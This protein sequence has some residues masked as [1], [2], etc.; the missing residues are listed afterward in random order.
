MNYKAYFQLIRPKHYL[1][2]VLI[3][4]PLVFGGH[5]FDSDYLLKSA[6][7]F[8]TFS[9]V[10]S[11][12]YVVNDLRDRTLDALHPKKKYRPV[13][14]GAISVRGA[15]SAAVALLLLASIIQYTANFSAVST[16]LLVF[17]FGINV[18]YSFGLK[19]IPIIDVTI[20]SL[21][22]VVRVFYGGSAIE[23]EVSKWLYLSI[24]A[25]SFYLSLGKRR[26]EIQTNGTKSRKVNKFYSQ[27]FLDK[28]MYVCLGLTIV[29]YSLWAIDPAQKHELMF[30][31]IPVV[32]TVVMAYS[33]AVE[34]GRSDGDPVNVLLGH[35]LLLLISRY[36]RHIND[37]PRIYLDMENKDSKPAVINIYD[38]D[39]TIYKGDCSLDFYRFCLLRKPSIIKYLP[40]QLVHTLLFLLKTEDRTSYKSNFFAYLKSIEDV[41]NIVNDFWAKHLKKMKRWYK[42]TEYQ[43]GIIISASPEFLLR[44]VL[45]DIGMLEIIA[46][47]MEEGTG[48]IEGKNCRG[49]EKVR[50][51]RELYPD[52]K[53]QT[54]YSDHISDKPLLKVAGT[55]YIV[56]GE[57]L[58]QFVE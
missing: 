37:H 38:F 45:K 49:D 4:L 17:Y 28:N 27:E 44:P 23:I 35:K 24:L 58:C 12:V 3:F 1:K 2:N 21:G 16:M 20:L 15:V 13:A 54:A 50:R 43:K 36:L 10:A 48:K 25:F 57:K 30:W 9:L 55:A 46:T 34:D 26:N 51:L 18:L 19:N 52:A 40:Y 6:Y 8:V 33:L 22:F 29:Y 56:R 39:H 53:I 31:T 11:A 42:H 41:N 47:R 5:L 14:S 7:A 32:I